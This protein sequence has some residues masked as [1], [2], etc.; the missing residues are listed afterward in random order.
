MM[1]LDFVKMHGLGNDFVIID[2]ISQSVALSP[3]QIKHICDRH[4]GIG[5]DQLLLIEQAR[6]Q[7]ADFFYRVYNGDGSSAQTCGNGARCVALFAKDHG[8]VDKNN[9]LAEI[10]GGFISMKI[11]TA[12]DITVTMGIPRFEPEQVPF[13]A[14][15]IQ[16]SYTLTINDGDNKEEI[17]LRIVS[18]GNPHAVMIVDDIEHAAVDR[19]GP[20]IESH[21]DFPQ[22]CNVG[23]MQI[24]NPAHI[25]LRVY[26]RG[27][28]ETLACGSGACAAVAIGHHSGVLEKSVDVDLPGGQLHVDWL[29]KDREIILRGGASYVFSGHIAL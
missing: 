29:A 5:C 16:D 7:R 28:G 14:A 1:K 6:D 8:L 26:E 20:L 15:H 10:D 9:L 18:I 21:P 3:K 22:R 11:K 12:N 27:A 25:R 2:A 17:E 24:L 4:F 13:R 19:L 23:F